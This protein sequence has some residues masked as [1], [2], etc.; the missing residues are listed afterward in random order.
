MFQVTAYVPGASGPRLTPNLD[1]VGEGNGMNG[2]L[3]MP[4][5]MIDS[6]YT[7]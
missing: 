2:Q 1:R 7:K 4:F 5:G 6:R 3:K